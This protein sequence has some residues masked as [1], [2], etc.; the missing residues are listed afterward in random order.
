VIAEVDGEWTLKFFRNKGKDVFLEAA[1][2]KYPPIRARSELRVGGVVS[3][4]IRKYP[5]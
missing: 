3:A 5:G 1:N 2:P 4:V